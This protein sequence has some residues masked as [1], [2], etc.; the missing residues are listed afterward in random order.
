MSLVTS[1]RPQIDCPP[2]DLLPVLETN[3]RVCNLG[4]STETKHATSQLPYS[5]GL[6]YQQDRSIQ[7]VDVNH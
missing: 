1:G 3:I 6:S 2:R 5:D 4:P 7:T